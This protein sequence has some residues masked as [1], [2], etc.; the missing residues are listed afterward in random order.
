MAS[1]NS[2]VTDGVVATSQNTQGGLVLGDDADAE[3]STSTLSPPPTRSRPTSAP[4]RAARSPP[5]PRPTAS[6]SRPTST[7]TRSPRPTPSRSTASSPPAP[8]APTPTAKLPLA[9][10]STPSPR[11]TRS[12]PTSTARPASR[13]SPARRPPGELVTSDLDGRRGRHRQ[14]GR[15]PGHQAVTSTT[16]TETDGEVAAGLD[17]DA[18]AANNSVG[19]AGLEAVTGGASTAGAT[20]SATDGELI[21]SGPGHRRGRQP[22]LGRRRRSPGHGHRDGRRRGRQPRPRRGRQHQRDHGQ[23][24]PRRG[25][26]GRSPRRAPDDRPHRHE[27]ERAS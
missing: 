9:S 17:I 23:H 11:P 22:Q 19:V 4:T 7:S 13:P 21:E 14:L 3:H 20:T 16:G 5:A 1:T 15:R 26:H 12:P 8:R 18:L 10:T 27:H 25:G 6:S 24:R 2:T